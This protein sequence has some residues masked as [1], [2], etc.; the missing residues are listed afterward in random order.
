MNEN[1]FR[2]KLAHPILFIPLHLWI[3]FERREKE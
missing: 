2:M 3:S 1:V